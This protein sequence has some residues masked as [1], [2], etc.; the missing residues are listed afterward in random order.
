M[1]THLSPTLLRCYSDYPSVSWG[2]SLLLIQCVYPVIR[3]SVSRRT[4]WKFNYYVTPIGLHLV[5]VE[6]PE[7]FIS[8]SL[9]S[10]CPLVKEEKNLVSWDYW[11]KRYLAVSSKQSMW[12]YTYMNIDVLYYT[13]VK[14]KIKLWYIKQEEIQTIMS[15]PRD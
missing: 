6:L 15:R 10:L 14:F 7:N 5:K 11:T 1:F 2:V 9:F 8:V 12:I 4:L 3:Q 13:S